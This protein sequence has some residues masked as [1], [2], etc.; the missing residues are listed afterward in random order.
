MS[1]HGHVTPNA[2]GTRAR[3]GGPGLCAVCSR[4]QYVIERQFNVLPHSYI[5]KCNP[6]R[7]AA[8]LMEWRGLPV[9]WEQVELM[10]AFVDGMLDAKHLTINTSI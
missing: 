5:W 4:E 1:G 9:D 2:D 10:A 7:A 8:V 3:C 6:V